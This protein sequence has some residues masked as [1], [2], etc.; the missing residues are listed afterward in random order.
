LATF[1]FL[2]HSYKSSRRAKLSNGQIEHLLL[3][4]IFHDDPVDPGGCL[5]FELPGWDIIERATAAG[6]ADAV[7]EFICDQE[8][9][10]TASWEGESI[11]PRG[12]F[13]GRFTK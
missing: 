10:I 11:R 13:V 7:I 4:P 9:G 6:F 5:V 3:P 12:I 2:C 1:P 8:K